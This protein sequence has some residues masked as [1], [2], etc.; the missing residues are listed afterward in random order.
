[1]YL[2]TACGG[3]ASNEGETE[4]QR[5]SAP[6]PGTAQPQEPEGT[7]TGTA[8][9]TA[10]ETGTATATATETGTETET[11]TETATETATATETE[12]ETETETGTATETET[13]TATDT[14]APPGLA[15]VA[16]RTT[17]RNYIFGHSL[18]L[19]SDQA[20]VPRFLSAFAGAS[21][22]R[23]RMAGQYGFMDMHA[24]RL[25]PRPQWGVPGVGSFWDDD[26]GRS[27][28]TANPNVVL[29]TEANFRQYYPPTGIDSDVGGRSS[30]FHTLRVIDWVVENTREAPRFI[31]YANWPDMAP[32]T[33]A[34]FERRMP[35]SAELQRYWDFTR[36]EFNDWWEAYQDALRRAR[37]ALDI[38]MVP[39]GPILGEL[40][41]GPLASI[42]AR[43]L[44]EDNAPHGRP[45]LYFLA[46]LVTYAGM[47]GERPPAD[48]RLPRDVAAGVR[49]RYADIVELVWSR[50]RRYDTPSGVSRVW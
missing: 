31:I 26:D 23:Y 13:E 32:Y 45:T 44:Y 29:M 40:L 24:S 7:E 22:K 28:R 8:A 16:S 6:A 4:R 33:E 41:T 18:V 36:G 17:I 21:G 3:L 35:S 39:V 34:D 49:E 48:I 10:T 43:E 20:N 19:H 1:S 38:D 50:L 11:E 37:P 14:S 25:P 46:S 5:V 47:F 12:T 30:V 2:A 9:A 42:P 15:A 27:Y